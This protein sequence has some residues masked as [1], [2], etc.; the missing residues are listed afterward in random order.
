MDHEIILLMLLRR[1]MKK[2]QKQRKFWVNPYILTMN[3]DGGHFKRKYEALKICGNEKFF[4]YFRMTITSFEQLFT[5][6][7]PRLQKQYVFRKPVDPIEKLGLTVRFLA[8][9]NSFRDM[10]FTDYRGKSTISRIVQEVCRA[11]W[12]ILLSE[13]IPTI[14]EELMEQIAE[15]FDK[16]TNFPNCMGALDG[17]HIRINSPAHS[18][19]LFFNYKNYNSIVLLGLVDSKYRFVYVDIGAYGK[20]C[21]STIF[22]NTKLYE[23]LIQHRLPIP[24]SKPLP[25]LQKP[26]PYVF[27]ADEG[28]PLMSNLMRPYSGKH[29]SIDQRIF[30]Y[31]LSR[32]RRNV[33]CAFGILANKWRIFHRPLNVKYDFATDIIKACCVLHNFVVSRDGSK[34]SE[35]LYIDDFLLDLRQTIDDVS[36]SNPVNI[37]D[38]FSKYLNSDVGALSWQLTKI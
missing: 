16:K 14:T 1:R 5:K 4:E 31:R 21:D 12:D 22:Q 19:S 23:L 28:L 35:E 29:L 6:L 7:A 10:E 26:V 9:G 38:E 20:E 24:V 8:T 13:C 3:Q 15:D 18:G 32:A 27:I 33:E 2:K 25:G 30:N 36:L 11:I 37:R 34:M 17:K